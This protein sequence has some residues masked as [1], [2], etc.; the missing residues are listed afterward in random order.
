MSVS[1]VSRSF[2]ASAGGQDRRQALR[3]DVLRPPDR[4][5][6]VRP[7]DL[8]DDEPVAEHRVVCGRVRDR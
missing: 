2:L 3:D 6:R 7:Q 1:I 5:R 8:A 4:G